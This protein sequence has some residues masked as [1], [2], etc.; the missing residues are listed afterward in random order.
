MAT[1]YVLRIVAETVKKG[2]GVKEA[3]K[4]VK[5]F[6]SQLKSFAKIGAA[7]GIAAVA[8]GA[9]IKKA[10]DLAKAGANITQLTE[11]FDGL[12][13]R[14]LKYPRL[15][16]DMQQATRGTITEVQL[17][18]GVMTLT[19]GASDK[20]AAAFARASPELAEI[21]KAANK[22]N[23]SLG[24][25]AFLYDSIGRG[26]KRTSPLILDNLGIIV[27]VGQANEAF[28]QSVGKSVSELTAEEKQ[29]ALLNATMKAG[30]K[31]IEQVGG[32][33]DAQADSYEQLTVRVGE[34]IDRA[35]QYIADAANPLIDALIGVS[36]E[37]KNA[38][39]AIDAF[40]DD[41]DVKDV[42]AFKKQVNLLRQTFEDINPQE[43]KLE[44]LIP[45]LGAGATEGNVIAIE[46]AVKLLSQAI[47]EMKPGVI[48]LEDM[49]RVVEE[50]GLAAGFT[51][52]Q[53]GDVKVSWAQLARAINESNRET[54]IAA[55]EAQLTGEA[56]ALQERI[57]RKLELANRDLIPVTQTLAKL[58]DEERQ[59]MIDAG[60]AVETLDESV[61]DLTRNQIGLAGVNIVANMAAI[62]KEQLEEEDEVIREANEKLQEALQERRAALGDYFS[63]ALSATE[64]Q[65]LFN[66]SL[67]ELGEQTILVHGRTALQA[68]GLSTLRDRYKS[69]EKEIGLYEIGVKGLGQTEDERAGKLTDLRDELGLV[70]AAM[71]PLLDITGEY[72][73]VTQTASFNEDA[74]NQALFDSVNAAGGSAF[75]LALLASITGDYSEEALQAALKSALMTEKIADLTRKVIDDKISVREARDEML[76]FSQVLEENTIPTTENAARAFL[77]SADNAVGLSTEVGLLRGELG[78]YEGGSPYIAEIKLDA[79]QALRDIEKLFG[80][81]TE[82]DLMQISVSV[83][84]DI[85]TGD[86][87]GGGTTTTPP[88]GEAPPPPTPP[89]PPPPGPGGGGDQEFAPSGSGGR[90]VTRFGSVVDNRD[91]SVNVVNNGAGAARVAQA[92]VEMKRQ[93]R[94]NTWLG[95]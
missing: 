50:L 6:G 77:A 10:F 13:E 12:N 18:Q 34:S 24:D 89:A 69:L 63:A 44:F 3:Q 21:A 56:M 39:A 40:I 2:T 78:L 22:L 85:P 80:F 23:P 51:G 52:T 19:A 61:K 15:L 79:E 91:Q 64:G 46:S 45:L 95:G 66:E 82:L 72:A 62:V 20:L 86:G 83:S 14:I 90:R 54:G 73:T 58:T 25:T 32:S 4:E 8:T 41:D 88:P 47:I 16:R 67:A 48:T 1:E 28:A 29:F 43:F 5:S 11:S 38:E 27:K 84:G 68:E 9:I 35:K 42:R 71:Q 92:W 57:T 37:A 93:Q 74:L 81:L 17:M 76:A 59:A 33:V 65:G 75:E 30:R 31:L 26:I 55:N 36:V 7:V 87:G 94:I 53:I 49:A 60:A 70:N